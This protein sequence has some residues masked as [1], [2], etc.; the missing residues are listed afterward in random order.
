MKKKIILSVIFALIFSQTVLA[1]EWK[2]DESGTKYVQEDG[3]YLT[4]WYQDINETWYYLDD[5]TGYILKSTITPDGYTVDATGAWIKEVQTISNMPSYDNV[6]ESNIMKFGYS[7]PVKIYYN[8]SYAVT[9][10]GEVIISKVEVAQ[11]GAAYILINQKDTEG[12][13]GVNQRF[14]LMM[15][16]GTVIENEKAILEL[17]QSINN[18]SFKLLSDPQLDIDIRNNKIVSAEVWI[19]EYVPEN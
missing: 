1:G 17:S 14:R 18:T 9:T 15:E 8:N 3:T 7:V 19:T 12:L 16:D 5:N 2:S 13:V 11:D 4:G 10:G 6:L